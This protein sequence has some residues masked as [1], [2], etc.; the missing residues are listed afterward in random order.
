MSFHSQYK[1]N[2]T[3]SEGMADCVRSTPDAG[4]TAGIS[5]RFATD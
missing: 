4:D 3:N 1:D 5:V 2:N